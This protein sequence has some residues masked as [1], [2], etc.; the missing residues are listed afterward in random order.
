MRIENLIP[1]CMLGF[2]ALGA[3]GLCV[4]LV[5]LLKASMRSRKSRSGLDSIQFREAVAST[6]RALMELQ[7]M[8]SSEVAGSDVRHAG[9]VAL[10]GRPEVELFQKVRKY[11]VA[12]PDSREEC[13]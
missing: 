4:S 3:I 6:R 7:N 13:N 9:S 2:L 12:R 10:L 1:Y 5:Q 11:Q 8:L